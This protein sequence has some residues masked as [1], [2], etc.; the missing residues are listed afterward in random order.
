[1]SDSTWVR[2]IGDKDVFTGGQMRAGTL[3]S[4]GRTT[5]GEYLQLE[6]VAT[7]GASCSQNGLVG[8]TAAGLTLSCQSGVWL[9]S[10]GL[11]LLYESVAPSGTPR[12]LSLSRRALVFVDS[13]AT[14]ESSSGDNVYATI[15][16]NGATCASDRFFESGASK[17]SSSACTRV[18]NPGLYTIS[19]SAY[20]SLSSVTVVG[21]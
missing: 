13:T 1:M 3:R 6:G 12:Y 17:V 14:R 5:V 15:S 21:L 19:F 16:I 10:G 7:E 4:D 2:S 11:D 18:L 8:R 9:R 20:T